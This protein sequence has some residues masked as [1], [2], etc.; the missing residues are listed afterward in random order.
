VKL[1]PMGGSSHPQKKARKTPSR[2]KRCEKNKNS[3]GSEREIEQQINGKGNRPSKRL[4][5]GAGRRKEERLV[6]GT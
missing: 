5:R 6:V 1:R 4:I 3:L 2:N